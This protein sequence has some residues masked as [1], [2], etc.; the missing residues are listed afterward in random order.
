MQSPRL[1]AEE[2]VKLSTEYA[3]M[4]EELAN[5]LATKAETLH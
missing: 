3:T 1:L 4:S 5:I 2:R